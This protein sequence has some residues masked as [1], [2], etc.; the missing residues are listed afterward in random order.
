MQY[1]TGFPS[2]PFNQTAASTKDCRGLIL[3]ST[4]EDSRTRAEQLKEPRNMRRRQSRDDEL[5]EP[6]ARAKGRKD[7][8]GSVTRSKSKSSG[9]ES[10]PL[11]KMNSL[12][13]RHDHGTSPGFSTV[14]LDHSTLPMK[15]TLPT[16][17]QP[18]EWTQTLPKNGTWYPVETIRKPRPLS[19]LAPP[20]SRLE[21][22]IQLEHSQS[23][24]TGVVDYRG[25][26]SVDLGT[27]TDVRL[28]AATSGTISTQTSPTAGN[29]ESISSGHTRRGYRGSSSSQTD[30][31]IN[32]L[33]SAD[34]RQG[35]T[36]LNLNRDC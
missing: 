33:I 17:Q 9:K 15:G 28:A 27:Q 2:E 1:E 4:S 24:S 11:E 8:S 12:R 3:H 21:D 31:L 34:P 23:Q 13:L 5:E 19:W 6:R 35:T 20:A 16:N 30:P 25:K 14:P 29:R 18:K 36:K 22:L 26:G 32:R 7:S 10:V